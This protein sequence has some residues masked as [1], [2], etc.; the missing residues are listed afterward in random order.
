V[1]WSLDHRDRFTSNAYDLVIDGESYRRR[2][3]PALGAAI[4]K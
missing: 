2:L 1:L 4:R 3:K